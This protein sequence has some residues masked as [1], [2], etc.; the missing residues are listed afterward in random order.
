MPTSTLPR[1]NS[2]ADAC[3]KLSLWQVRDAERFANY[4]LDR[5]G[6]VYLINKRQLNSVAELRNRL[7]LTV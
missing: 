3:T 7:H 5:P 1:R 6:F 2:A 4:F